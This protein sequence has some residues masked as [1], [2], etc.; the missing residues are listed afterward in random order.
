MVI[1]IYLFHCSI[2]KKKPAKSAYIIF[3]I[4]SIADLEFD[5]KNYTKYL[6]IQFLSLNYK[7][8]TLN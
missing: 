8:K 5:N 4:L 6:I 7:S 1:L 3:Y 2:D